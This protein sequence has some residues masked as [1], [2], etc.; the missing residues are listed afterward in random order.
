MEDESVS[1]FIP[2]QHDYEIITAAER[3]I[4]EKE[5]NT[6][7]TGANQDSYLKY[8]RATIRSVE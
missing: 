8:L 1:N 3:L 5:S 6:E 2:I 4:N 7:K